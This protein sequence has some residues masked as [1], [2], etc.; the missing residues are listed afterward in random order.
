LRTCCRQQALLKRPTGEVLNLTSILLDLHEHPK[1][2]DR[3]RHSAVTA[4]CVKP[5][6]WRAAREGI[7]M[8]RSII[9]V[10]TVLLLV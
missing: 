5:S 9:A 2:H 8:F 3:P 10:A 6:S 7:A 4:I 1:R